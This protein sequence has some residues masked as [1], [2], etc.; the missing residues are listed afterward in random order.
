MNNYTDL[1]F[2][3]VYA[4]AYGGEPK[5][6]A[7]IE[8]EAHIKR[9]C[10]YFFDLGFTKGQQDVRGNETVSLVKNLTERVRQE[11]ISMI[12]EEYGDAIREGMSAGAAFDVAIEH[13]RNQKGN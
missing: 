5:I 13:A 2:N 10:R 9:D 11:T 4:K 3:E 1:I 12:I 7:I 8:L 6:T